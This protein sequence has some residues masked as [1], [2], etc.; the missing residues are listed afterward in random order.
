MRPTIMTAAAA[1][2]LLLGFP[3][4]AADLRPDQKEAVEKMLAQMEPSLREPFRAQIE[5][6]VAMLNEAQIASLVANME[7]GASSETPESDDLETETTL[8]P[9]DLAYN[10]KQYEPAVRASWT[11]QKE[12]DDFADAELAAACPGRDKYAVFGSGFRYELRELSPHWPRASANPDTDVMVLGASYAPQDGRYD[13]DFSIVRLGFDKPTVSS[14]IAKACADWTKEAAAFKTKAQ[15]FVDT[16]NFDAAYALERS[17]SGRVAP[18]EET[19][20][21]VLSEQAPAADYALFT[22]LQNGRRV[23]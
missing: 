21:R 9:E 2:A 15:A 16:E 4:S 11:A 10:R 12:F 3:A 1:A 14:A 17:A 7:D 5:E 6:S 13:F 22:A 23:K 19:L 20:N 8:S 18:I